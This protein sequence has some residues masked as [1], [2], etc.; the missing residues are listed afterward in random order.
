MTS[1]NLKCM[2]FKGVVQCRLGNQEYLQTK[3][4]DPYGSYKYYSCDGVGDIYTN[5]MTEVLSLTNISGKKIIYTEPKGERKSIIVKEDDNNS[6]FLLYSNQDDLTAQLVPLIVENVVLIQVVSDDYF[7]DKPKPS[8]GITKDNIQFIDNFFDK[9][10]I[11]SKTFEEHFSIIVV[12]DNTDS[13]GLKDIS[14]NT[15]AVIKNLQWCQNSCW[16]DSFLINIFTYYTEISRKIINKLR[17]DKE[18]DT[19]LINLLGG[20]QKICANPEHIML[21]NN[22]CENKNNDTRE[23]PVN[24]SNQ[25]TKLWCDNFVP[26]GLSD[27]AT[28]L[29]IYNNLYQLELNVIKILNTDLEPFSVK[30][31]R[32]LQNNFN[33]KH[34]HLIVNCATF[35]DNHNFFDIIDQHTVNDEVQTITHHGRIFFLTSTASFSGGHW[36]TII[37]DFIKKEYVLVNKTNDTLI[38]EPNNVNWL[39]STLLF[40]YPKPTTQLQ[41]LTNQVFIN[42]RQ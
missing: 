5:C 19:F 17:D 29:P 15:S 16:M 3:E 38:S 20:N 12:R 10:D 36:T 30:F 28:V 4:K 31:K 8:F 7:S 41:I 35:Q 6:Y 42:Q 32:E 13:I 1:N 2:L 11:N 25:P 33:R 34:D 9:I 22:Y 18:I 26:N 27:A 39:Q 23:P 37:Y 21:L 24:F 40:Y 14:I